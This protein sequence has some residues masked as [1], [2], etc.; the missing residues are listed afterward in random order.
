MYNELNTEYFNDREDYFK[1]CLQPDIKN[2]REEREVIDEPVSKM[3]CFLFIFIFEFNKKIH[4]N[5]RF[6]CN[7]TG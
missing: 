1:S 7:L 3:Y 2:L 4:K 6:K 5:V